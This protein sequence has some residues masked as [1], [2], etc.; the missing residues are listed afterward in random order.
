MMKGI[1]SSLLYLSLFHDYY[2]SQTIRDPKTLNNDFCIFGH[3]SLVY[4]EKFSSKLKSNK[5]DKVSSNLMFKH[6]FNCEIFQLVKFLNICKICFYIRPNIIQITNREYIDSIETLP[7]F[8][9]DTIH[10]TFLKLF[11][12]KPALKFFGLV[13]LEY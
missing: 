5:L 10:S 13:A 11:S 1:V 7:R 12:W 3:L 4:L 9:P 2:I 6:L 8:A